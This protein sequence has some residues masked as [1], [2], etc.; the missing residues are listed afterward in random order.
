MVGFTGS[1][2]YSSYM[3]LASREGF[4]HSA[5]PL[6][7]VSA[8]Q[9]WLRRLAGS[10]RL[11]ARCAVCN[12]WPRELVCG[13]CVQAHAQWVARC[14]ACAIQLPAASGAQAE[15]SAAVH[16]PP[17]SSSGAPP[18]C[19][20]CEAE[21]LDGLDAVHAALSY[22][23]PWRDCIDAFKFGRQPGWAGALAER[24]AA[25]PAIVAALQH[26]DILV[27][28]PLHAHRVAERGYSQT[29][30]LARA[31]RQQV[32]QHHGL[33]P[34]QARLR[35]DWLIRTRHTVAQSTLPLE[36]RLRNLQGAFAASSK[37]AAGLRGARAVLLDD[38]MTSGSTLQEA[39][40]ALHRAGCATV[41]GVV[42]A[43]AE[44]PSFARQDTI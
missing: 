43:R 28:L 11:P 6:R 18:L 15:T 27:P 20:D 30:L 4:F 36:E 39:A 17:A 33:A 16:Q 5:V 7:P 8:Q 32:A 3:N 12:G 41:V 29:L 25:Q 44:K 31:L 42:L 14:P 19:D 2:V 38:V 9:N 23:W 24:M 13:E 1:V 34:Q 21:P 37:Q 35:H 10:M 40:L 22:Q 26:S